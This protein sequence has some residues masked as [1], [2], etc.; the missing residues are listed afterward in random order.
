MTSCIQAQDGE[1]QAMRI[2]WTLQLQHWRLGGK[3]LPAGL[4]FKINIAIHNQAVNKHNHYHNQIM[5]MIIISLKTS[6]E[7]TLV[8]NYQR[9]TQSLTPQ[10]R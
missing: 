10:C 6:L 7:A 2:L 4:T 5:A 1:G 9:R 8:G 3:K